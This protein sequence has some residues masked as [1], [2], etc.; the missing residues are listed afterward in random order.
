MFKVI[1]MLS[2]A[3][4]G[5][6][7]GACTLLGNPSMQTLFDGTSMQNWNEVGNADWRFNNGYVEGSGEAGFLVSQLPYGDFRLIVEFWADGPAN[8]GVFIRC[9]DNQ[10]IGA[11]NCYEVN[12]FDTR[13]DQTYRTGSIVN[14]AAPTATIDAANRWN[15]LE[16]LAQGSHLQV[17]LNGVETV[18]V[19]DDQLDSGYIG[20]QYGTGVVRFREVRIQQL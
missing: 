18:N 14:V 5:M 9:D 8:S 15:R 19:N 6:T 3:V 2:M 7:L 1:K 20:L 10:T 12:V 17:I 13:P 16:I 11:D 4:L